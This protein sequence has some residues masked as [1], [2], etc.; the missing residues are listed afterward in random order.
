[1]IAY[2]YKRYHILGD[3]I[4]DKN[5]QTLL[6]FFVQQPRYIEELLWNKAWFFIDEIDFDFLNDTGNNFKFSES[7][8]AFNKIKLEIFD[9]FVN[10]LRHNQ[11]PKTE[12]WQYFNHFNINY[13]Y[14]FQ[15][16]IG[17]EYNTSLHWIID[18]NEEKKSLDEM[19]E[20]NPIEVERL[21]I[22][23]KKLFLDDDNLNKLY[24]CNSAFT[25]SMRALLWNDVKKSNHI[26]TRKYEQ[27]Q[28]RLDWELKKSLGEA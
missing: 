16:Y 14:L 13:K 25:F 27:E 20:T 2:P 23:N 18:D 22:F 26:E 24:N 6:E 1:M 7:T 17:S 3:K 28:S 12:D 10:K 9:C 5:R 15:D 4:F 11:Y 19:F 21:L 8:K